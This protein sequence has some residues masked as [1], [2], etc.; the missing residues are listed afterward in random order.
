MSVLNIRVDSETAALV[1]TT[2]ARTGRTKS[3]VV[4]EALQALGNAADRG[5]GARP[6]ERVAHLIGCWDSG[7]KNLSEHTGRRFSQLLT[8][9]KNRKA[10]NKTRDGKP[11]SRR[12]PARRSDRS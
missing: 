11:T 8:E 3:E 9:A 6:Y 10:M 4:R 12:R 2:A 5:S 7:G 1:E